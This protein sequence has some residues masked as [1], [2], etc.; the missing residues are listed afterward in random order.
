[1]NTEMTELLIGKYLDSEITPAEQRL[2]DVELQHNP[3]ARQLWAE[4]TELRRQT[5]QV[6]REE[7]VSHGADAATVLA[8]AAAQ[9]RSGARI[10]RRPIAWW[11]L[12]ATAASLTMIAAV[13]V[14]VTRQQ[15]TIPVLPQENAVTAASNA[16]NSAR[17]PGEMTQRAELASERP[18]HPRQMEWY[19]YTD[20]AG[21]Q[22]LVEA[23][24][25][26]EVTTA[27]YHGGL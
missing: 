16:I 18:Q 8:R 21:N 4:M 19:N 23:Y 12:L 9:C 14:L 15:Q 13:Y 22:W 25:D 27:A 2:L 17:L 5:E 10:T 20:E 3:Q 7:I 6:L 24:R 1:M 26:N 11:H